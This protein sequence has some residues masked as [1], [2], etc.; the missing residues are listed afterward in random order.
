MPELTENEAIRM[1]VEYYEK[2]KGFA[3]NDAVKVVSILAKVGIAR[4]IQHAFNAGGI[5]T[6]AERVGSMKR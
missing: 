2:E 6:E 5:A 4:L 1:A 3:F